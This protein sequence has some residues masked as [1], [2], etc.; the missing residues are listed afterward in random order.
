MGDRRIAW[1]NG[2]DSLM[3]ERHYQEYR[4]RFR[5]YV[6]SSERLKPDARFSEKGK[7]GDDP[8]P[9]QLEI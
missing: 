8:P 9:T 6:A 2:T 7:A 4:R 3:C 1:T 5:Q